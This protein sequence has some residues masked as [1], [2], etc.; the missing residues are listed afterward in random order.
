[1]SSHSKRA[2]RDPCAPKRNLS[3]YLLYQNAMRDQFKAQN[4]GM[5]FGQLSKFTS[6]MYAEMSPGEKVEWQAKAEA[7]KARYLNELAVYV[8]PPGYDSKGDAIDHTGK[9]VGKKRSKTERDANAPKRNLSAYLLYQNAMRD[10]FKRENPGMTFGQLS[11]YT[12]HMYKNLTPDER[13]E[14]DNRAAEDKRRYDEQ[15]AQYQPP[16]G[17]DSKGLL[18]ASTVDATVVALP[19]QKQLKSSSHSQQMF[20]KR[21]NANANANANANVN[22]GSS[23]SSLLQQQQMITAATTQQSNVHA[24]AH[25]LSNVNVNAH[26]HQ[27]SNGNAHHH[28]GM[29]LGG[30]CNIG[31]VNV[32]SQQDPLSHFN[33]S[34]AAPHTTS[35]HVNVNTLQP[36]NVNGL[37]GNCNNQQQQQQHVMAIQS[38]PGISMPH[39]VSSNLT[40]NHQASID[41]VHHSQQQQL[42]DTSVPLHAQ[43]HHHHQTQQHQHHNIH[44]PHDSV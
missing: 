15:M 24:H 25:Q 16:P 26:A 3:A 43:I 17:Y 21:N 7:D 27:L 30:N 44:L 19:K 39:G 18:M 14:W 28:L 35:H 40:N 2:S 33:V 12:S 4:P 9:K 22:A 32:H 31:N 41:A 20:I 6:A 36:T 10:Q 13:A 11:K 34:A 8:P 29:G 37:G 23:V 42:I 5:T 38:L 1:M